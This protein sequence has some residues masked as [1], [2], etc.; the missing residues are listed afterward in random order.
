[1]LTKWIGDCHPEY[2]FEDKSLKAWMRSLDKGPQL[3][4]EAIEGQP[5]T[6]VRKRARAEHI[7]WRL[8]V[9]INFIHS[10]KGSK[11]LEASK[12]PATFEATRQSYMARLH[13]VLSGWDHI[14][15]TGP[16]LHASLSFLFVTRGMY[17]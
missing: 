16:S 10:I 14:F 8:C 11:S 7:F 15:V 4:A 17:Q 1:M 12:L 3:M 2:M 5:D 13:A 6:P 9:M